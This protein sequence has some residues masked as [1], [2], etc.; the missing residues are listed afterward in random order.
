MQTQII[1][2]VRIDRLIESEGAFADADFLFPDIAPNLIETQ[3]DWLL[4]TF[5]EPTTQKVIMSFHSLLIRSSHS[6]I[7]VDCCVGN[8]HQ[9]NTPWLAKLEKLGL[10]PDDIDYVLCTHLHADHV[11]WN[12]RL[13]NGQWVPTFPNA[14]YVFGQQ[15]YQY[16]SEAC[17]AHTGD[18]PLNHGSFDDS[19]LP[20]INAGKAILVE[21]DHQIE[22]GIWLEPAPGH[23]PGNVIVHVKSG[24]QH[25]ILTGDVMHSAIQLANPDLNSRFC[26]DAIPS[27]E[28]RKKLIDTYAETPVI[29]MP[30]H[31][32]TPTAGRIAR[33]GNAFE[34]RFS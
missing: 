15:E 18:T 9:L 23:T 17:Q 32:P 16:W 2:D 30:A 20:I 11:G 24:K 4:P 7:L 31:F 26:A 33:R 5:V 12:T 8:W 13:V 28:S 27:R 19:V 25:A 34:Y 29:M 10:Q 22:P 3:A 21:N 6:T 14:R 1:G